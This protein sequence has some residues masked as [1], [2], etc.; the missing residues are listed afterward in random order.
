[1]NEWVREFA[2]K[3]N[4]IFTDGLTAD[5]EDAGILFS[6]ENLKL[7]RQYTEAELNDS[8]KNGKGYYYMTAGNL[9]ILDALMKDASLLGTRGK[10]SDNNPDNGEEVDGVEQCEQ[11]KKVI[12]MLSDKNQ[13]NFRGR[14]AGGFLECVLSDA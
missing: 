4:D 5:G 9:Q 13:F 14:D 10:V 1:M 7:D 11:V 12:S 8:A 2:K 6:A 3:V